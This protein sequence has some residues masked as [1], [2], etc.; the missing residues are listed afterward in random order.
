MNDVHYKHASL[1]IQVSIG[2]LAAD[3]W[4]TSSSH[5]V[6]ADRGV[7]RQGGGARAASWPGIGQP[8]VSH[9]TAK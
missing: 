6:G 5:S 9:M 4:M 8:S 7:V 3:G 2:V 1:K